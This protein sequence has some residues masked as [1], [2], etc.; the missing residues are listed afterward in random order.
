[1]IA[2][3]RGVLLIM[4]LAGVAECIGEAADLLVHAISEHTTS[5]LASEA[6]G[7]V[8]LGPAG[9]VYFLSVETNTVHT[10]APNGSTTRL[11]LSSTP[12]G[13]SASLMEDMAIDGTGRLFIPSIWRRA[14]GKGS[15]GIL[16]FDSR[17][18]YERTVEFVPRTNVRHIAMDEGGNIFVLGIDPAYY[19]GTAAACFLVHKYSP[20]GERIKAFSNCPADLAKGR[21][22]SGPAWDELNLDVDRGRLWLNGGRLYQLLSASHQIRVFDPASGVQ[23]GQVE[24][25]APVRDSGAGSGRQIVWRVVQAAGGEYLAQWSL[26]QGPSGGGAN[27]RSFAMV[28]HDSAGAGLSNPVSPAGEAM[29]PLFTNDDG[30][31]TFAVGRPN[32]AIRL[33]QSSV[34]L[35]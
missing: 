32:G 35:R 16:V 8:R 31:I 5:L 7:V 30:T 18:Y 15:A 10:I 12:E 23:V 11:A 3:I 9:I 1:M 21:L 27:A 24:L 13:A 25:Q 28:L 2:R 20:L 14:P 4:A 34:T 17:G 19:R 29:V 33:T 26:P 22:T 6:G